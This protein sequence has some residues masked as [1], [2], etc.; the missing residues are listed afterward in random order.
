MAMLDFLD[1][2]EIRKLGRNRL[3]NLLLSGQEKRRNNLAQTVIQGD[4]LSS[5]PAL[6]DQTFDLILGNPPWVARGNVETSSLS[7]WQEHHSKSD[8]PIPA[9]QVACAFLWEVPR[10]LKPEGRAC[11]LLPALVLLGDQTDYFQ[12]SWFRRHRVEA[13]AQLSDLRLF[14]FPGAT[15]PAVVLRFTK[16]VPPTGHRVEY[17]TP[18]ANYASIASN[19]VAVEADDN[20]SLALAEILAN[21]ARDEAARCWLS[22][23]WA[24]PRDRSFLSRYSHCHR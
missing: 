19:V 22:Y 9:N 11:L 17:L 23:N 8:F 14:L 1:P 6:E 21:A 10:Y 12:L 3:P 15:H 5:L 16:E 2:P 20:K 4:F 24:T 7:R 18:K 13:V